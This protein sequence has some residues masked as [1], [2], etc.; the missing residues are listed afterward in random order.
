MA[1]KDECLMMQPC[2]GFK[3]EGADQYLIAE[4][5]VKQG[6]LGVSTKSDKGIID[7]IDFKLH[8]GGQDINGRTGTIGHFD[9]FP[10]PEKK[11][12]F[13]TQHPAGTGLSIWSL[14]HPDGISGELTPLDGQGLINEQKSEKGYHG[15]KGTYLRHVFFVKITHRKGFV[16]RNPQVG[17]FVEEL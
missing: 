12:T 13:V 3:Y 10:V 16:S 7:T 14:D 2:Q 11:A 15:G 9:R 8:V 4:K 17:G 5:Y 1:D 6:A